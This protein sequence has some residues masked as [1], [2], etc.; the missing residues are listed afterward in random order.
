MIA[1]IILLYTVI[2]LLAFFFSRLKIANYLS[3][4]LNS[5]N[6]RKRT[7]G[8]SFFDWLLYKRFSDIFPNYKKVLYYSHYILYFVFLL[9]SILLYLLNDSMDIVSSMPFA[10]LMLEFFVLLLQ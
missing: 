8:Q 6:R 10:Y 2:F 9:T 7:K 5:S 1:L 4:N 3:S